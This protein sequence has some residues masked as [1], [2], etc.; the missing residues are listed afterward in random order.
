MAGLIEYVQQF[1]GFMDLGITANLRRCLARP[2]T[3]SQC[4]IAELRA[5]CLTPVL[6]CQPKKSPRT[7][8]S[9]FCC[10]GTESKAHNRFVKLLFEWGSD[11]TDQRVQSLKRWYSYPERRVLE[12]LR[13]PLLDTR[14]FSTTPPAAS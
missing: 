12:D 6:E 14:N 10:I 3:E 11:V 7:R 5:E 9:V 1:L 2:E 13:E 8:S 4:E